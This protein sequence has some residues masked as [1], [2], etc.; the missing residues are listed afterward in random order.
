MPHAACLPSSRLPVH[1]SETRAQA[2]VS[3]KEGEAVYVTRE[4]GQVLLRQ[5]HGNRDRWLKATLQKIAGDVAAVDN[6]ALAMMLT[7]SCSSAE[8]CS[9]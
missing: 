8:I 9:S 5:L 6:G 7:C 4:H 3:M 2:N 1:V